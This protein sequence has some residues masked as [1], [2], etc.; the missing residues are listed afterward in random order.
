MFINYL[1]CIWFCYY[2]SF[3]KCKKIASDGLIISLKRIS[4]RNKLKF[5]AKYRLRAQV[6]GI[7]CMPGLN[8]FYPFWHHNFLCKLWGL[9]RLV[10]RTQITSISIGRCYPCTTKALQWRLIYIHTLYLFPH[11]VRLNSPIA[12]RSLNL[13]LSLFSTWMGTQTNKQSIKK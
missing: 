3:Q 13:V 1:I 7:Y 2:D 4:F 5:R 6:I 10:N 9:S 11:I 8:R 12:M